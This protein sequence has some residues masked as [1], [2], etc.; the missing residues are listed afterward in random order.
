M[1]ISRSLTTVRRYHNG[2]CVYLSL[3]L[4][5]IFLVILY[6]LAAVDADHNDR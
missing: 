2:M 3:S 6:F 4:S 1:V 5:L